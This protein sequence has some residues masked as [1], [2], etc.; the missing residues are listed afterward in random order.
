M[1][2]GKHWHTS[3][4]PEYNVRCVVNYNVIW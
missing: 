1:F 4:Q 2:N 3:H